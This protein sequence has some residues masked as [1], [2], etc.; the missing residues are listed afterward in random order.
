VGTTNSL[1]VGIPTGATGPQGPAGTNANQM[2]WSYAI[3]GTNWGPILSSTGTITRITSFAYSGGTTASLFYAMPLSLTNGMGAVTS[4]G[5]FPVNGVPSQSN[6]SWGLPADSLLGVSWGAGATT[7]QVE[8]V[9]EVQ[10]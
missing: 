1:T 7:Q 6:L 3:P 8:L 10:Q 4:L 2:V 9:V 5:T